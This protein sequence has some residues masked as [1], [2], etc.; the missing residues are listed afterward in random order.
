MPLV[1]SMRSELAD[2]MAGM[3]S[4]AEIVMIFKKMHIIINSKVF[5]TIYFKNR[6]ESHFVS[7]F[8]FLLV[9]NNKKLKLKWTQ[10]EKETE[11]YI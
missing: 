5:F 8:I 6:L 10:Q 4:R 1:V 3:A 7:K 9:Y 2:D 11:I